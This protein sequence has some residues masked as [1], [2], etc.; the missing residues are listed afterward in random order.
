MKMLMGNHHTKIKSRIGF[1]LKI[2]TRPSYFMK[3]RKNVWPPPNISIPDPFPNMKPGNPGNSGY[4]ADPPP[5]NHTSL[6]ALNFGGT[7]GT[8][9]GGT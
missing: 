3:N 9:P 7:L 5:P 4:H 8:L 6:N 1:P 2:Y